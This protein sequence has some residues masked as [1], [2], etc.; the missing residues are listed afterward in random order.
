MMKNVYL[1]FLSLIFTVFSCKNRVDYRATN[2]NSVAMT[3]VNL[4]DNLAFACQPESIDTTA[5]V[6]YWQAFRNAVINHDTIDLNLMICDSVKAV[7]W[8]LEGLYGVMSKDALIQKIDDLFTPPY[9]TLLTEFD[10]NKNFDIKKKKWIDEYN[11]CRITIEDTKYRAYIDFDNNFIIY[12]MSFSIMDGASE[13]IKLHFI[14]TSN[15]V[16][17]VGMLSFMQ[18]IP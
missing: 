7:C 16:K 18:T 3:T 6:I 2:G 4:D 17:L 10:I 15:G 8:Q 5:F 9:L 13:G 1:L 11:I 14:Q 12:S